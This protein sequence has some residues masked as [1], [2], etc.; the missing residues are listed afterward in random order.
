MENLTEI[1]NIILGGCAAFCEAII[2]QP[3]LYWKNAMQQG[4]KFTINPRLLY[5]GLSASLANEMGQMGFQFGT[6]GYIKKILIKGENRNC[7]PKEEVLS[8]LIGG[9]LV[10][11]LASFLE[12]MMIQQQKFGGTLVQ[13]PLRISRRYG[14][15][16]I[17]RGFVSCSIRD[18]IYVGC[19]LGIT[20]ILQKYL[21][22]DYN[23][24]LTNSGMYASN[25]WNNC[26]FSN[27]SF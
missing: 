10:A 8:A 22:K 4:L 26:R 7:T 14:T 21:I 1:E 20:P 19:F 27:M 5:R 16:S 25:W 17:L 3:T 23:I 2:L 11:P 9:F 24:S 13:T 6:T 15:I 12:C 18:S